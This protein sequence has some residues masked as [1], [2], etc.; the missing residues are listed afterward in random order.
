VEDKLDGNW[1]YFSKIGDR[2][3]GKFRNHMKTGMFKYHYAD[4][5]KYF[6]CFKENK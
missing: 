2:Y 6:G 3:T 1:S 5:R 4:G